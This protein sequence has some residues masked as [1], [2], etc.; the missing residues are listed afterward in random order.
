MK[1]LGV[2]TDIA[3]AVQSGAMCAECGAEFVKPHG[4]KVVCPYCWRNT[5]PPDR[6]GARK[7]TH[8][9]VAVAAAKTKARAARNAL[10]K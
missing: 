4:H 10:R 8:E 7:A 3:A 5:M 9:E 1:F 2:A 6:D